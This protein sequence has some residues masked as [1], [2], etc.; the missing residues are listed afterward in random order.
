M[1]RKPPPTAEPLV[2]GEVSFLPGERDVVQLPVGHLITHE[3]VT[4]PVHVIRGKK[5]GPRIFVCAGLHGDELNGVETIRRFLKLRLLDRLRGDLLA[6]PVVNVPAFATRARYLPDRRDLNRLFPGSTEGSFGAR[7]AKIF[8]LTIVNQCSM[9]IDLHTGAIHRPNLPHV[10]IPPDMPEC[11]TLAI[12]FGAPIVLESTT[13]DGSLRSAMER[14]GKPILMFEGGEALRLDSRAIRFGVSGIVN[15]LRALGML[16]PEKTKATHL[17]SVVISKE[18]YWARAPRG[19]IVTPLISLGR[20]VKESTALAFIADPFGVH[21]SQVFPRSEGI[22]IGRT[23]LGIADEGDGLY[24]I[25]V[26]RNP[27]SAEKKIRRSGADLQ[28]EEDHPV[29]D[30][31]LLD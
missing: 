20:A 7:L 1:V 30:D 10:R 19:G 18:S 29:S 9:G 5:P 23:T 6:V 12:A 3:L 14:A 13:R 15:V 8:M 28:E 24:H 31:P 27:A 17:P 11:R 26:T 2:I 25:A 22:V 21:E 16:P 4:M